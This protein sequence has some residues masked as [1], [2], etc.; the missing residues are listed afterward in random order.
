M[1]RM[2]RILNSAHGVRE[3]LNKKGY[4]VSGRGHK[5]NDILVEYLKEKKLPYVKYNK[6]YKGV[7]SA[8]VK[9]S[10]TIQEDWQS[11]ANWVHK[12]KKISNLTQNLQ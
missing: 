5:M 6:R 3:F 1:S 7:Y 11:F 4:D 12:Q 2:Q 9:N 8:D 10:L